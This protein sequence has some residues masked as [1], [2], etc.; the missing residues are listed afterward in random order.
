MDFIRVLG[1]ILTAT[2]SVCAS[3][4]IIVFDNAT[5]SGAPGDTLAFFG[6]LANSGPGPF[7]LNSPQVSGLNPSF[8]LNITPFFLSTPSSIDPGSDGI[9]TGVE[10]FD[11]GIPVAQTPG[12]YSGQFA[13]LGG[14]DGA[15]QD[16]FSTA[17]FTVSVTNP[18]D[19]SPEP[20]TGLLASG[21]LLILWLSRRLRR[22]N[23]R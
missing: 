15:A 21:S 2:A 7:F 8:A 6:V 18:A 10:F 19:N 22:K 5:L 12:D 20:V 23:A 14:A 13:I 4:L 9:L 16:M 3:P 11:V 17:Q 1:L